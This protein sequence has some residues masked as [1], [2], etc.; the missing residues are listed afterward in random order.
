MTPPVFIVDTNV[1]V[2][3]LITDSLESPV[4]VILDLMLAG[5]LPYLMSP[6]LLDEY[7]AVLLRPTITALHGLAEPD[8]DRVLVELAANGMWREPA[9]PVAAPDPGDDHLWALLTACPGSILVTGDRRLLDHP[10]VNSSVILPR[11]CV[12][13]FLGTNR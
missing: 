13:R 1:V 7:R 8:I 11:T 5:N 4:A 9:S 12:E 10:P 3:G 6:A 2:A